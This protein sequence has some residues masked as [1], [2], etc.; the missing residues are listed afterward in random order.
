MLLLT[1]EFD[2]PE[3]QED[4]V[5]RTFGSDQKFK[6]DDTYGNSEGNISI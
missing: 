4:P 5:N 3:I 1:C 2:S 6:P